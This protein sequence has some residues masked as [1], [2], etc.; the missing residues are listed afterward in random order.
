MYAKTFQPLACQ[1]PCSL[2]L[3]AIHSTGLTHTRRTSGVV[4]LWP[5]GQS[6]EDDS[7]STGLVRTLQ[8]NLTRSCTNGQ[9]LSNPAVTAQQPWFA[10][11]EAPKGLWDSAWIESRK[12]RR[13]TP[14]IPLKTSPIFSKICGSV[15]FIWLKYF[16]FYSVWNNKVFFPNLSL[17]TVSSTQGARLTTS[18]WRWGPQM[19]LHNIQL[20]KLQ[21][22]CDPVI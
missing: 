1:I 16:H 14:W 9:L 8:T 3:F 11:F 12:N 5:A 10:Q 19:E 7:P 4:S 15:S 20:R 13:V 21:R 22:Y 6:C 17:N 2:W 18:Y